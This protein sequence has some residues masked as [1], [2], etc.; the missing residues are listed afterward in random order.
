MRLP[1]MQ[2]RALLTVVPATFT[3]L[4]SNLT[5][6]AAAAVIVATARAAAAEHVIIGTGL[7]RRNHGQVRYIWGTELGYKVVIEIFTSELDN[8]CGA[9]NK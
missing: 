8:W 1:M 2:A 6:T 9:P 3:S 4:L 5:A 7:L